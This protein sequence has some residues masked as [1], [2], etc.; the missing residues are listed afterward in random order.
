MEINEIMEM[1]QGYK[2]QF[3]LQGWKFKL[4]RQMS[5]SLGNCRRNSSGTL[6]M[7]KMNYNHVLNEEMIYVRDTMLH[8]IAH[9]LSPMFAGHSRIWK[10]NAIR[11]GCVPMACQRKDK[12]LTLARKQGRLQVNPVPVIAE[13]KPIRVLEPVYAQS[14][15]EITKIYLGKLCRR[16]VT[17][18]GN[19]TVI[20]W[21]P[22][23]V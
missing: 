9:A 8:E 21:E 23:T 20:T 12:I 17:Q 14:Q 5:R 11:V 3:D 10:A 2:Q 6:K 13:P 18:S 19:N 7:I 1:W 4:S 22:V 15:N 16:V